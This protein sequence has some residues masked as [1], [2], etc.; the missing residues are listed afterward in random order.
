[1]FKKFLISLLLV[2]SFVA[3]DEETPDYTVI[4]NKA[5][6]P[7]LTPSLA[8]AK[9]LK[10]RLKNGLE[11]YLI[12][13]PNVEKS[14]AVMTVRVGS[15]DEP[16]DYPGLAHFL[17]HM[18]FLG[19]K[20]YPQESE[21]DRYI[22]EHGGSTN[23]FTANDHT[24]FIF[25][26]DNSAF[27]EALDRFSSFYKEPLF[28]P[29]GVARELQAIDQEYAKNRENDD[30]RELFVN[31]ETAN[32]EHPFHAFNIGNSLTLAKVSQETLKEWYRTHYSGSLMRLMV[33]S[34][35]PIERLK[36]LV[37]QDFKDVPSNDRQ[38]SDLNQNIFS[39]KADGKIMYIE[40][41]KNIRTVSLIWDLPAKF[42]HMQD[43]KPETIICY[44][45][46][47]EGKESLLA[48]LQRERLAEN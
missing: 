27:E 34:P 48:E 25:T 15:W 16:K 44:V 45:L 39:S 24:S 40:P 32:P 1:M 23:A 21:Y 42:S 11:A 22:T 38:P 20:K 46:G 35:L 18:L 29:S 12:S 47:H 17:E 30:V 2:V 26:I 43:S 13:D 5:T 6:V 31:K 36:D 14:S 33:I 19:T 9:V 3:A 7:L 10:I 8:E 41:V 28:N 4:E 37:V